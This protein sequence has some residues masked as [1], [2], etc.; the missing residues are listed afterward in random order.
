M[1]KKIMSAN[2]EWSAKGQIRM[3]RR[4]HKLFPLYRVIE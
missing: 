1:I 4:L 3:D 2:D